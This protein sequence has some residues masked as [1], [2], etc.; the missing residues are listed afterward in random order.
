MDDHTGAAWLI[1]VVVLTAAYVCVRRSWR[2]ARCRTAGTD[3]PEAD[4][5]DQP[6]PS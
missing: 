1:G 3:G 4:Y 6:K 2:A 5:R